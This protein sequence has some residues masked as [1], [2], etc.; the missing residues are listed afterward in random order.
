MEA[1]RSL[2]Y[3]LAFSAVIGEIA[4]SLVPKSSYVP[5]IRTVTA[6]FSVLCVMSSLNI[7]QIKSIDFGEYSD[8]EKNREFSEVNDY[9]FLLKE[10][11]QSLF[12]NEISDDLA[13]ILKKHGISP[14]KINVTVSDDGKNITS[15]VC[16]IYLYE[17]DREKYSAVKNEI[18]AEFKMEIRDYYVAD[19]QDE[20]R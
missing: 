4:V 19:E 20:Q 12:K 8:S 13:E 16:E 18:A 1:V 17:S 5:I 15:V 3:T 11:Q 10:Q 7:T 9:D 6:L 14:K 2:I